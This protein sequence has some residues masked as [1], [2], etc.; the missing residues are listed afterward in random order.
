MSEERKATKHFNSGYVF[1]RIMEEPKKGLST[2]KREYISFKVSVSG[3]KCGQVTIYCR[4]WTTERITP[5]L[6]N[7]DRD[8]AAVYAL[9][10][11]YGQYKNDHNEF[12]SNYTIYQWEERD[13]VIPRASFIMRGVVDI[14]TGMNDGGQRILFKVQRENQNEE[15]FELFTP[16]ELL[17][18]TVEH[19]QFIE[20]KG[21]VRQ[22]ETED[23]FGAS[24]G[25]IRAFVH[26]LKVLS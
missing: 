1:G 7:Y 3:Q 19:G 14:V 15:L 8:P 6:N 2:D 25:P 13:K 23:E 21:Y 20:V 17:L 11:F 10:G 9:K 26:E 22:Q 5:F 4:L 18:D 16:G 12:L 24:S